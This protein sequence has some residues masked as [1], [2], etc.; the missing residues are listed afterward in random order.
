MSNQHNHHNVHDASHGSFK[1]YTIGFVL[2][3]LLAVIPYLMVYKHMLSAEMLL[4]SIVVLAILRLLVQLIFFLHLNRESN[5]RWNLIAFLFT[6]LILSIIV[7]GYLWIMY[8]L[9]LNM[10]PA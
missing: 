8:N 5:P 3:L 2:S 1:S 7:V 10:M 4:V 6:L 9:W